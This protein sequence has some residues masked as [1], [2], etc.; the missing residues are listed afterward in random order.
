LSET[1][2]QG[3]LALPSTEQ[4]SPAVMVIH[5]WWGLNAF[6][7]QLCDRLAQAGFVAYAP[8]LYEGK[9][10]ETVE[11]AAAY[12]DQTDWDK[13]MALLS[14]TVEALRDHPR[15]VDQPISVIGF[16]LGTYVTLSLLE[17]MPQD[18]RAAVIFYGTRRGS[19]RGLLADVLGHFAE[20]DEFEDQSEVDRLEKALKKA[21][22]DTTFYTYPGTE[23]WFFES[24]QPNAYKADAAQLAWERT[25]SF[26][27]ERL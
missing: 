7:K 9:V 13:A 15:T 23:H 19:Y 2:Q 4:P 25:V 10:A 26:L 21:G 11:Q 5:A 18:V 17:K 3:Y 20:T 22:V 24:D 27:K 16:S 1:L 12:R 6:F 14:S 8:D